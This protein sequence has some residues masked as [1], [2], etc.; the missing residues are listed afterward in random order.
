MQR[1]QPHLYHE[2]LSRLRRAARA[3]P[4][5]ADANPLQRALDLRAWLQAAQLDRR[6]W[7]VALDADRRLVAFIGRRRIDL[8]PP[9]SP[10][11]H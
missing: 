6:G 9:P 10:P 1:L 4:P 11:L 8:E 7:R 3:R 5:L 2:A